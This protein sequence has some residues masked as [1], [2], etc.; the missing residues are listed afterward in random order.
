LTLKGDLIK[1]AFVT[2]SMGVSYKVKLEKAI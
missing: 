1:N 2:S